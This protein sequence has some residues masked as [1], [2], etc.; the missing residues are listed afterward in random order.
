MTKN[1]PQSRKTNKYYQ[2]IEKK[3][4]LWLEKLFYFSII[5][6]RA[7]LG[8]GG[9][10][11]WSNHSLEELLRFVDSILHHLFFSFFII[12]QTHFQK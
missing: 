8:A 12:R 10:G 2:C 3:K 6:D 1:N 5:T 4:L 11:T 9:H 7:K